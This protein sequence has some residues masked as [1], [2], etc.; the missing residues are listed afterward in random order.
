MPSFEGDWNA[1]RN[2]LGTSPYR[3]REH[4]R[5][6][7]SVSQLCAKRGKRGCNA[8]PTRRV[9]VSILDEGSGKVRGVVP[10]MDDDLERKVRS[11]QLCQVNRKAPPPVPLHPWEG[12]MR[13]WLQLHVDFTRGKCSPCW[14]TPT[15]NGHRVHHLP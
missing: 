13:P 12:P 4:T 15:Q 8:H 9:P 10:N 2:S 6:L 14:L 1:I 7:C 5:R 3:T 11:C